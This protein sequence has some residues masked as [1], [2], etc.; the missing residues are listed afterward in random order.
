LTQK[1]YSRLLTDHAVGIQGMSVNKGHNAIDAHVG[2]RVRMRRLM[3][4]LTQMQLAD[5]LGLTFQQVQKYEKGT[6]RISASRLHQLSQILRVPV[7]FFFE[8]APRDLHLPE[9]PE[10][11]PTI[12]SDVSALLSTSDGIALVRA[13]TRI[14]HPRIRRAIV[15]LVEQIVAEPAERIGTVPDAPAV[16]AIK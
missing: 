13:Y 1:L 11:E 9:R 15:A 8:G 7:P 16:A 6:N 5:G 14:E 4:D 2:N 10:G 3:L 12:A